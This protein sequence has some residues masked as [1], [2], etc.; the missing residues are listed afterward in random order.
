MKTL[1]E[2]FWEK[3]DKDGPIPD[4]APEL[5][6]CWIWTAGKF[7]EDYGA[8]RVGKRTRRAHAVAYELVIGPIPDGHVP[9]HLCRN[10]PCVRPSHLEAVTNRENVLRGTAP[11]A[12]NAAKTHCIHNHEFT[13]ENT[14]VTRAGK[15]Q[16]RKCLRAAYKRY[17]ARQRVERQ[18]E[19]ATD[20]G[21]SAA[22]ATR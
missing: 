13:P 2:R 8:F 16:C 5:G 6:N 14:K 1:D 20:A 11:S 18:K 3:V 21:V 17:H 12:V 10:H 15:R 19:I 22:V 4:S 9:D 7:S